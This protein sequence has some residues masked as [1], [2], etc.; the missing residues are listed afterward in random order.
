MNIRIHHDNAVLI[1]GLSLL[2]AAC[3]AKPIEVSMQTVRDADYGPYPQ[4]YEQ[5]IHSY[6][7]EALLDAD[8]AKIR[9][10]TPPRK[11]F[12]MSN[13]GVEGSG[14]AGWDAFYLVCANV[15]AKNAYGG[16]AGW[17]TKLYQ[18]K[19]GKME[20]RYPMGT[21]AACESTDDIYIDTTHI[22]GGDKVNIVP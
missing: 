21:Y 18:F 14:R 10:I 5:R 17:Q 16:Y 8:S 7:N 3:V 15:N 11:V 22:F 4:D 19:D 9:I 2:L 1:G 20:G 13:Q 6:L 12:R